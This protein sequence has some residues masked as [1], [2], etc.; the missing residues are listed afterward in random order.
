MKLTLVPNLGKTIELVFFGKTI[1]LCFGVTV[2]VL[3]V[4]VFGV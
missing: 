2:T 3:S 4:Y 1:F